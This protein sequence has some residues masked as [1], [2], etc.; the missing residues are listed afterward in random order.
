MELCLQSLLAS[1]GVNLEIIV[2]D[3]DSGESLDEELIKR[4]DQLKWIHKKTNVGFASGVNTALSFV[5]SEHVL[6]LNPDTLV[7]EETLRAVLD[8]F[9]AT[10]MAG[11][12]GI[13]FID[14]RGSNLPE[15]KRNLPTPLGA[16]KKLAGADADYYVNTIDWGEKSEVEVL[17]GAF[18]LMKTSLLQQL[19]GFDEQFFMY[20]EDIDLCYRILQSGHKLYYQGS[21]RMI[22]F[23]GESQRKDREYYKRFYGALD[24]YFRKHYTSLKLL[25]PFLKGL[26]NGMIFWKSKKKKSKNSPL[27]FENWVYVGNRPSIYEQLKA[28]LQGS[29]S[30]VDHVVDSSEADGLIFDS[31]SMAFGKILDEFERIDLRRIPKRILDQNGRFYLGSDRP[32]QQGEA[33]ILTKSPD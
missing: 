30:M 16:L 31:G 4:Y 24:I 8:D 9:A 20:G 27:V 23:K 32:D 1:K 12:M 14:G 28:T 3:N 13:R 19:G 11:A 21:H 6:I 33:T 25:R 15:A 29:G 5:S 7:E 2:V 26:T 17:T 22:H 18:L 10:R